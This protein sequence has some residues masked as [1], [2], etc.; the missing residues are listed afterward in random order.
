MN[1]IRFENAERIHFPKKLPQKV[2]N[3]ESRDRSIGESNSRLIRV[4]TVD[5]IVGL[6]SSRGSLMHIHKQPTP[7][8]IRDVFILGLR[9]EELQF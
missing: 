8:G 6:A 4:L 9:M 2:M 3:L 5:Q 1:R 7:A